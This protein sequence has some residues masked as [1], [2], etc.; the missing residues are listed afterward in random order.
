MNA[1][2]IKICGLSTIADIDAALAARATHIGLVFFAKSPRNVGIEQ[3]AALAAHARG[4]AQ[5]VGLFVD[6]A[7]EFLAMARAGVHLDAIQLHGKETPAQTARIRD[8]HGIEVW[9]AIGVRK[10]VDLDAAGDFVGAADRILYDAKPPEGADLPGGTGL[11]I[12]WGLMQGHRH[13]LPWLLA[14]GLGPDNVAQAVAITGAP[15]VDVSSGVESAPGVKDPAKIA[16]FCR[17][18]LA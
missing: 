11:R 2:L 9:K 6:P 15:G 18:V 7:A 4:R 10:R 13:P 16:A 12:D 17:A 3:A 5:V 1:P 14:G 8:I